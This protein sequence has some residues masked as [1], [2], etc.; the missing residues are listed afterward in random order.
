MPSPILYRVKAAALA[1]TGYSL[2]GPADG[3]APVADYDPASKSILISNRM[4]IKT[5]A[6]AYTALAEDTGSLFIVTAAVTLSVPDPVAA[7]E[8]VHYY[9]VVGAD[10]TIVINTV[11]ANSDKFVFLND[12]A[13]DSISWA[14]SSQKIG[15]GC[16]LVCSGALWYVLMHPAVTADGLSVA[17]VTYAT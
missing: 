6:A 5:I 2:G 10:V 4:K 1:L 13:G 9:V 11:T 12:A 3:G 8:G 16:H 7:V 14:G 15:N 17:A